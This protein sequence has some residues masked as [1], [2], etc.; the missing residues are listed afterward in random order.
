MTGL[1]DVA[2]ELAARD[3]APQQT[4]YHRGAHETVGTL[5]RARASVPDKLREFATWC[6]V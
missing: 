5:L 3:T 1:L 6:G 2:G 4:R